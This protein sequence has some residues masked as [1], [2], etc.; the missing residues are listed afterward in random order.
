[1][2][3]F[4]FSLDRVLRLKRQVLRLA[5]LRQRQAHADH[6][7]AAAEVERLARGL[8]DAAEALGRDVGRPLP[9]AAWLGRAEQAARAN[10]LLEAAHAAAR[11]TAERL[12]AADRVRAQAATE[13]EA[14]VQLRDH[15]LREF[16]R[17]VGRAEQADLDAVGLRRWQ[18]AQAG[19]GTWPASAGREDVR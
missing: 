14:L 2:R 17:A 4:D 5:E 8:D 10:R 16:H 11:A 3:R 13:V 18:A 1:M 7:A 12:R 15:R 19:D 6:A 9:A